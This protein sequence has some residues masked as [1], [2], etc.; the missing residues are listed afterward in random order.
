MDLNER[1]ERSYEIQ[2]ILNPM[3]SQRTIAVELVN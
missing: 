3:W 2:T 1:S